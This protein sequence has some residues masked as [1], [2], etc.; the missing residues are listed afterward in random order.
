MKKYLEFGSKYDVL[1]AGY[2]YFKN[3]QIFGNGTSMIFTKINGNFFNGCNSFEISFG[4]ISMNCEDYINIV[5]K[6]GDKLEIDYDN[7]IVKL[8]GD[9]IEDKNM[10]IDEFVKNIYV[11][12]DMMYS[13]ND[14]DNN[15]KK[16][17]KRMLPNS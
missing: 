4:N 17:V 5:F 2:N 8:N 3:R 11:N 16:N 1:I 12:K 6:L 9:L 15:V 7:S 10:I 14:I 13:S